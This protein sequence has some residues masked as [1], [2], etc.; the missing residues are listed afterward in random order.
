M[1]GARSCSLSHTYRPSVGNAGAWSA[2]FKPKVDPG[3]LVPPDKV[4]LGDLIVRPDAMIEP[5]VATTMPE[6][7]PEND[8]A[9]LNASF[10]G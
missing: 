2:V 7:D 3:A 9:M 1:H 4:A 8:L 6:R 10:C 5:P